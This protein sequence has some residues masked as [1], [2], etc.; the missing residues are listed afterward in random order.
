MAKEPKLR[1]SRGQGQQDG[2]VV[3]V[4]VEQ[5]EFKLRQRQKERTNS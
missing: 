5:A 3:K 4:L 2:P 1:E